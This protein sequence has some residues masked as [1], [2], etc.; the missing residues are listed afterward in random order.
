MVTKASN[1]DWRQ[2]VRTA[3]TPLLQ[4]SSVAPS[5]QEVL[6]H[7][8]SA[9]ERKQ[10]LGTYIPEHIALQVKEVA[11]KLSRE[12]GKRVTISDVVT[13]ALGEYLKRHQS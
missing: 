5:S 6:R 13:E 4:E 10:A 8:I 7:S 9:E 11:V 2:A 3:A 1:A 12:R